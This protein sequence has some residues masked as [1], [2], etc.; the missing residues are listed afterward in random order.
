MAT[1]KSRINTESPTPSSGSESVPTTPT[2]ALP[3][4]RTRG[5]TRG[6]LKEPETPTTTPVT[7]STP[8]ATADK[9][10]DD[11][12][13]AKTAPDDEE[14]MDDKE[15]V[16]EARKEA[17]KDVNTSA[18]KRR[19]AAIKDEP[20]TGASTTTATTPQ[21][22][23]E[24]TS[25]TAATAAA[26]TAVKQEE[27]APPTDDTAGMSKRPRRSV[28]DQGLAQK[29][30]PAKVNKRRNSTGSKIEQ[31]ARL[32]SRI[33]KLKQMRNAKLKR[34]LLKKPVTAISKPLK[35]A[36]LSER[37][38]AVA[39]RRAKVVDKTP[40]TDSTSDSEL[41]K[42]SRRRSDS[43][44]KC[45][46]AT[47]TSSF[48]ETKDSDEIS[49][50][51]EASQKVE[52]KEETAVKEEEEK[53][54][55]KDIKAEDA[56]EPAEA[57]GAT[58]PKES[59]TSPSEERRPVRRLRRNAFTVL[60]PPTAM[61]TRSRSET[62]S[63][64]ETAVK[65]A[66]ET[67]DNADEKDVVVKTEGAENLDTP[68]HI[69][70]ALEK[71]PL[72]A[73]AV[74]DDATFADEK[75]DSLSPVLVSEGVS[76]ICVKQFYGRADF[77]EN[78]LGIEEDPK[79]G[80]IVQVKEKL[81]QDE[82]DTTMTVIDNNNAKKDEDEETGTEELKKSLDDDEQVPVRSDEHVLKD[83]VENEASDEVEDEAEA[84]EEEAEAEE[85]EE[86]EV[87]SID[88]K[89]EAK[90]QLNV[91]MLDLGSEIEVRPKENKKVAN[92]PLSNDDN[93]GEVVLFAITNGVRAKP[94][95]LE[96]VLENQKRK[97]SSDSEIKPAI[98]SMDEK[99]ANTESIAE[100]N[101]QSNG[102][103]TVNDTKDSDDV[104]SVADDDAPAA[105]AEAIAEEKETIEDSKPDDTVE[106]MDLDNEQ[107]NDMK[108]V[109]D[110][111]SNSS[112]VNKENINASEN[113]EQ[114]SDVAAGHNSKG[115]ANDA[116][117]PRS[118]TLQVTK[119]KESHLKTLGLLTH[120]EAVAVTIEKEKRREQRKSSI[121]AAS[122]S[123][124]SNGKGKKNVEYTGTLKTVIKLHK[125]NKG[126]R[127][128][129]KMTLHK[130]R[131]KNGNNGDR[132]GSS[133]GNSEED[134]YYTIHNEVQSHISIHVFFNLVFVVVVR[135]L[136][137]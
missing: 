52:V 71:E 40:T 7:P 110:D 18:R 36:L 112:D 53:P 118:E 42:I 20:G 3:T 68:L 69:E 78:N 37:Q 82:S 26:S 15:I 5:G 128:P 92:K 86:E 44:S 47:D 120:R 96:T 13:T 99:P 97:N 77:L 45:S 98:E 80:E 55:S 103:N 30:P 46:D 27:T 87:E 122:S 107:A 102:K 41:L 70:T 136:C 56:S 35:A 105:N 94:E 14:P 127:M 126:A 60:P 76:E 113:E 91:N 135:T 2:T 1:R 84:E 22:S 11:D 73:S 33:K 62:P 116:I 81:K 49:S 119:Q 129:L 28:V 104:V 34:P 65:S 123:A 21:K 64:L 72:T 31:P 131:G 9:T 50:T 32:S 38:Q 23:A 6:K 58:K 16:T 59:E 109:S 17:S 43:V 54:K 125:K 63:K 117:S 115:K 4:L 101:V 19:L 111:D 39:N 134:T 75:S 114:K 29:Q 85:E 132:D 12:E 130:G 133:A 51:P 25:P 10:E 61:S 24:K 8:A 106:P 95:T 74:S 121:S 137:C 48:Q 90:K 100:D 88:D 79:L 83:S 93:V 67:E 66:T 108:S 57:E 124:S 89:D